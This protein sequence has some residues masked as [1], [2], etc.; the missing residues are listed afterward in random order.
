M[1][2]DIQE[3]NITIDIDKI[4]KYIPFD[5]V[6]KFYYTQ[7]FKDELRRL[8]DAD[9]DCGEEDLRFD[10]IEDFKHP[11]FMEWLVEQIE[12]CKNEY[13]HVGLYAKEGDEEELIQVLWKNENY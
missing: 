8:W 2:R 5:S 6:I 12:E 1:S 10:N 13:T 3:V 7:E 4:K 11:D 9:D